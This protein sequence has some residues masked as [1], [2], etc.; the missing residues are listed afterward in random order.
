M[1]QTPKTYKAKRAYFPI[2]LPNGKVKYIR[3]RI[4]FELKKQK[5]KYLYAARG[6]RDY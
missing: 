2:T 6:A 4:D 3:S 1:K 5:M